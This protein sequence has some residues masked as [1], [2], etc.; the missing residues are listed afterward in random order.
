MSR[1][2]VTGLKGT[3]LT[4]EER[5]FVAQAAPFGLILFRRNV[6]SPAQLRRLIDAFR[7]AAGWEAPVL[8]DQEGGRVQRLCAPH[9]R[10]YPSA[11][12]LAAAADA[13]DDDSLIYDVARLMAADLAAVGIT[14]DCAPCLDLAVEGAT[15]AIG[16]RSFGARAMDVAIDGR[17]MAA[18]LLAGGVMPVIKHI[19]GHGRAAVDSHLGLPVVAESFAIL[20]AADFAP[21]IALSDMPAAM[22][23]HVVYA[24]VDPGR[25][26]SLSPVVIGDIIRD[27][28]GFD[29]LLFSDDLSMK[30]LSGPLAA[31]AAAAVGA[32]CD[33]ALY[34]G[35]DIGEMREVAAAV[36]ELSGKSLARAEAALNSLENAGEIDAGAIDARL[37]AALQALD[38][39]AGA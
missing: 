12:R 39:A 13:A 38:A 2:F 30:A 15:A 17:Q 29:G 23:A 31:R 35:G 10:K 1:A 19:P 26:A 9:W 6:E 28:I 32:G 14:V 34:C 18:G 27:F 5:A 4:A 21:F 16:D 33:I 20:Q 11:A 22:T 8:V 7:A 24:A 25:P 3:E 36:P 37:A